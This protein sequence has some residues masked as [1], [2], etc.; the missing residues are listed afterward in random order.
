MALKQYPILDQQS[1]AFLP[2][3]CKRSTN[4]LHPQF[5]VFTKLMI[6]GCCSIQNSELRILPYS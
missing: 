4:L 5:V 3:E 6:L 2:N 1:R